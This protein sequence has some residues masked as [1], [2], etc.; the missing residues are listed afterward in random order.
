VWRIKEAVM[1]ERSHLRSPIL[2]ACAC[3]Y[4]F[5]SLLHFTHNALFVA[6]YPNLP[7]WVTPSIVAATWLTISAIGLLAWLALRSG[8]RGLGLCLLAVYALF[9]FDAFGHYGLA[10]FDAHSIAMNVTILFEGASAIALFVA[11]LIQGATVFAR[12]L[13]E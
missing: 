10:P 4:G 6:D 11:T 9:G 13:Q 8:A 7:R 5:A 12:T 1:L 2:F 3:V